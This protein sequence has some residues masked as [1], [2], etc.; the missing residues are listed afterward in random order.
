MPSILKGSLALILLVLAV[1]G[2]WRFNRWIIAEALP[3]CVLDVEDALS[4]NLRSSPLKE[5][6]PLTNKWRVLSD[7]DSRMLFD[8]LDKA[9]GY[10]CSNFKSIPNGLADDGSQLRLVARSKNGLAQVS[11]DN[12]KDVEHVKGRYE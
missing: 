10:D 12:F 11:V 9:R 8:S 4:A 3:S 2:G 6:I 5:T 7:D 1:Y